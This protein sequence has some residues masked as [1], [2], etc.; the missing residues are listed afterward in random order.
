MRTS[1]LFA[2]AGS[3]ASPA[4]ASKRLVRSLRA[5]VRPMTGFLPIADVEVTQG[6]T[7]GPEAVASQDMRTAMPLQGFLQEFQRG[8]LVT[9]LR[10]EALEHLT[11]VR[12]GLP[13]IVPL[14]VDRHENLVQVAAPVDSAQASNATLAALGCKQRA[15]HVPPAPHGLIADL[16]T[17]LM[18]VV[19]DVA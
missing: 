14:T 4:L 15:E 1:A 9:R 13:E 6:G 19:L 5:I 2:S 8:F 16:N 3:G 12:N 11:F 17:A 10:H 7:M 18:Q